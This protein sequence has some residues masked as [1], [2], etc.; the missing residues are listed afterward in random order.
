MEDIYKVPILTKDLIA[1]AN[2]LTN[3]EKFPFTLEYAYSTLKF[4]GKS[5]E[6]ISILSEYPYLTNIDLSENKIKDLSILSSLCGLR[7]L[8]LSFNK[9]EDTL[10]YERAKCTSKSIP[11]NVENGK[12][13]A[14]IN[15]EKDVGSFLEEV[16][17][18]HNQITIMT[19]SLCTH[20]FITHLNLSHNNIEKIRNLDAL[21]YLKTLDL[22]FNKI[23]VV[24]GLDLNKNLTLVNLENN[25]INSLENFP[26]TLVKLSTLILNAN[27]ISSCK[28][29]EKCPALKS[30]QLKSNH[31]RTVNEVNYLKQLGL[32]HNLSFYWKNEKVH[33]FYPDNDTDGQKNSNDIL[34]K[35][36]YR[37]RIIHRLPQLQTLD[38]WLITA[39]EIRDAQNLQCTGGELQYRKEN[40]NRNFPINHEALVPE[41]PS[42]AKFRAEYT[43]W[44]VPYIDS[45]DAKE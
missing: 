8:K 41:E 33:M 4:T 12:S 7:K 28:G 10:N 11:V 16:D 32:L 44:V 30:L 1:E 24:E 36:N 37:L 40:L 26:A 29:L 42:L 22:S 35:E 18:D 15:G 38:D 21:K 2:A 20:T 25:K 39:E 13:T 3:I 34:K 19:P 9:L 17:L 31:I 23:S 45:H 14:W 27:E 6:N 5:I 43:E